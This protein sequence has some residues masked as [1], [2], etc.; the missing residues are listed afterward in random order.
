MFFSFSCCLQ[1]VVAILLCRPVLLLLLFILLILFPWCVLPLDL[2][3][4]LKY[5]MK[6]MDYQQ[7]LETLDRS[8]AT[9]DCAHSHVL[10]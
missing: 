5:A 3:R 2:Q 4:K 8:C 7:Q 1:L 9:P 10:F 6:Y